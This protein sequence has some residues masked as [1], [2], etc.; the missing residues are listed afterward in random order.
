[1]SRMPLI[2][3][4]LTLVLVAGAT[5][6]CARVFMRWG[7]G[8]PHRL[9]TEHTGW[10]SGG[11]GQIAV[12]GRESELQIFSSPRSTHRTLERL[13]SLYAGR[14]A[15][16]SVFPAHESG[17][18]WALWPDRSATR[19]LVISPRELTHSI[20][21]VTHA[22]PGSRGRDMDGLEGIQDYPGAQPGSRVERPREG[23]VARFLRTTAAPRDVLDFYDQALQGA[24][25]KPFFSDSHGRR[26]EGPLAVYTRGTE[27]CYISLSAIR[28]TSEIMI[29]V[30][31]KQAKDIA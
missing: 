28:G 9:E 7:G 27:T 18:G 11:E 12:N 22:K 21:F 6:V 23:L 14:G 31:V 10:A 26:V 3:C 25:W 1:M 17:W 8:E 19:F 2:R 5:T 13:R 29:T 20:V 15:Q 16:V 4:V 30:L 24:G